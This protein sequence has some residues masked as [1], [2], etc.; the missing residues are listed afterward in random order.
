[1][2][3]ALVLLSAIMAIVVGWLVRQTLNVSPWV[4]QGAAEIAR[5]N[6][7]LVDAA[8]ASGA[9]GVPGRRHVAVRAA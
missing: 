5:G 2:T 8:G 1:M 6:G 9:R 7:E 4:E 3:T